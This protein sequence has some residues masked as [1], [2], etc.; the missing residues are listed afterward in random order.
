MKKTA[1]IEKGEDGEYVIFSSD[2]ASTFVGVGTT[3]FEA[4]TQFENAVR[5]VITAYAENGEE[6]PEELQG[7]EFEYKEL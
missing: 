1:L 3:I 6:L 2:I 7:V 5:E 4:K